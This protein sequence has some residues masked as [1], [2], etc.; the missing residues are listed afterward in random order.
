VRT[1]TVNPAQTSGSSTSEENTNSEES[2][3]S[4]GLGT[5][6][7]VGIVVGVVV[8][9][10]IAAGLAVFWFLRRR[11]Q[12]QDDGY[13]EDPSVRGGSPGTVGTGGP[14]MMGVGPGSAANTVGNRSSVLQIDPRMD[15]FRG[16]GPYARAGSQESLNTLRDDHDYSRRIQQ[17]LRATNPD[18]DVD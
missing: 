6:A 15:P 17:P 3:K 12:T 5:G 16:Q 4:S 11:K 7:V 8:A 18:P 10:L 14:E 13:R 9:V 1:V 2:H